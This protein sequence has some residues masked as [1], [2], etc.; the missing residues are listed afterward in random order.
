MR[1]GDLDFDGIHEA[2]FAENQNGLDHRDV[3]CSRLDRAG[4]KVYRGRSRSWARLI[5]IDA[6]QAVSNQK[7]SM[8]KRGAVIFWRFPGTRFSRRT[9]SAFSY[10]KMALLEKMEPYQGGGSM[11]SEVTWEKTTWA[12]VPHKFEAGTPSIAD[13]VGLDVALQY[14][15]ALGFDAIKAHKKELLLARTQSSA[16]SS[17]FENY[18]FAERANRDR[19]VYD[20]RRS[21]V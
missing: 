4:E 19:L 16:R 14:V 7:S 9:E 5:M 12:A 3:E 1:S 13:A 18:R 10:G 11:I 8:F 2:A 21:S 15:E 6:A 20:G 17:G